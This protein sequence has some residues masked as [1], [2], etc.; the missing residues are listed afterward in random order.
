MRKNAKIGRGHAQVQFGNH[1]GIEL[2]EDV[3]VLAVNY[4]VHEIAK[5]IANLDTTQTRGS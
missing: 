2:V 5:S 3:F 4:I 1:E